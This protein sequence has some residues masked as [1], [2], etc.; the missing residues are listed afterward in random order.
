MMCDV[1]LPGCWCLSGAYCVD[2]LGEFGW[3][4]QVASK[5]AERVLR[6]SELLAA[7][8]WLAS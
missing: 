7:G 3:L 1:P 4:G 6:L 5:Q 2:E 8:C